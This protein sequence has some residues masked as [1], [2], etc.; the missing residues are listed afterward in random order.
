MREVSGLYS[1]GAL[2]KVLS[3]WEAELSESERALLPCGSGV[4]M[5]GAG[6]SAWRKIDTINE[7]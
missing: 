5:E 1:G 2:V 3:R 4:D 6:L 7:T